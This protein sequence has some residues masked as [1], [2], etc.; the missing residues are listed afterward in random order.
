MSPTRGDVDVAV[1]GGT[2]TQGFVALG[3][4]AGVH[5]I[6]G[7]LKIY[8]YTEPRE[9]IV[10][11]D[12]WILV[13]EGERRDVEVEGG[14]RQAASVLAKI[15]GVDGRD[16]AASLVG[17]EIEVERKALPPCDPGEYYWAD[18]EGLEVVNEQG[19]PLG[20]V[21]H[22]IATGAND[23]IVLDGVPGRLIP[24]VSGQ[25]VKNVD[26]AAGLIVVDWDLSFWD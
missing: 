17:A 10:G 15:R 20:R 2:P 13:H 25:V 26:I 23:V 24:F 19:E 18:L 4:I 9:N 22:M 16:E 21:H 12:R 5:G 8:S 6:N 1:A 3:R 14:R 7:W 11:F